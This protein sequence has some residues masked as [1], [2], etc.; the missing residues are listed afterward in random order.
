VN[1]GARPQAPRMRDIE[2][3]DGELR[4]LARA[5]RVAGEM[6]CTPS[7]AHIDVLLDERAS[8]QFAVKSG[9]G[10]S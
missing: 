4:L 2:T 3:I 8:A 10:H 9:Q 1:N 5:W 6:N 7:T